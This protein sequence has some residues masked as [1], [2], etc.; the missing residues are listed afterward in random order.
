MR[1]NKLFLPAAL[2]ALLT[3]CGE[4]PKPEPAPAQPATDTTAAVPAPTPDPDALPVTV[5]NF[6][7]AETDMY[8]SAIV[9]KNGMGVLGHERNAVAADKQ[10]VVRL[11]RDTYYSSG[12]FDLDAGPVTITMPDA[13]GRFQS[14]IAIDNDHYI[15]GVTYTAGAR[16]FT[17]EKVGTRYL[18]L[19]VRTFV[20]PNDPKDVEQAH[21]L[22]DGIKMSQPGGPGSFTPPKWDMISQKKVRDAL[23]VLGSTLVGFDHAFGTRAE[24]DPIR[25]L[26][27][28][29]RGWGGNPDK[30]ARYDSAQPEHND[31]KTEYVLH[32]KDVP[33][34]GFWSITVY[35]ATGYY[36]APENAV[37]VNNV[38]AKKDPDGGI[39]VH[40]G[41][42]PNQANYLRIMDGWNY[43]V[44]MYRPRKEILDGTWKFPEAVEVK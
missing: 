30:D 27:G 11:N 33:V 2:C 15:A 41:G 7:R 44:R 42:D 26:I 31:G 22:Q 23:D 8:F 13:K 35:N 28:T 24:V 3:S 1:T 36:E 25:H 10:D 17:R 39:T 6:C 20:D 37:S 40:F 14:L 29:A 18:A 19:A 9:K 4:A 32:V 16:T 21:T 5:D 43:T 12:V 38:T 34:D